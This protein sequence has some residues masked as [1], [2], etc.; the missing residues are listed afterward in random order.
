MNEF[1]CCCPLRRWL[2]P[3]MRL[4]AAFCVR[5]CER[6]SQVL[7]ECIFT[8]FNRTHTP[9]FHTHTHLPCR[10]RTLLAEV[11]LNSQHME[12][13]QGMPH[14]PPI[15]LPQHSRLQH[16]QMSV[17]FDSYLSPTTM[18]PCFLMFDVKM[19]MRI[20]PRFTGATKKRLSR[21]SG[22]FFCKIF[23]ILSYIKNIYRLA[24]E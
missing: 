9:T 22:L 14:P 23:N 24:H 3:R 18:P 5:V 17:V 2:L 6:E 8:C 21:K 1:T 15:H 20:A 10:L 12:E 16:L 4:S 11:L 7:D 13:L 19:A